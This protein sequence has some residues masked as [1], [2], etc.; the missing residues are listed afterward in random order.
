MQKEHS[1]IRR[2]IPSVRSLSYKVT[3]FLLSTFSGFMSNNTPSVISQL[4]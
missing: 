2:L 4:S 1:P 3:T